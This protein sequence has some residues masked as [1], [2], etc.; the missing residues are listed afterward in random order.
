M[1]VFFF[2][3]KLNRRSSISDAVTRSSPLYG[4]NHGLGAK[5]YERAAYVQGQYQPDRKTRRNQQ[6]KRF[7]TYFFDLPQDHPEL[8]WPKKRSPACK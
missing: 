3:F 7:P 8:E 6:G 5:T 4:G 1:V 2:S